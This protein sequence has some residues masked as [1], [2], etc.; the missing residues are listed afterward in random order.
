MQNK[1]NLGQF[2]KQLREEK[3]VSLKE[4]ESKTGLSGSYVNRIENQSRTNPSLDSLS[5]LTKYFQIPF[6]SMGEFCD[7]GNA[8]EGEVQ[9]LDFIL[10]NE[11]YMFANLEADF[12]FKMVL[13]DLIGELENYCTKAS[14][15]RQGE[16]KIIDFVVTL[17]EK[18]LSA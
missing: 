13:R 16:A 9:N 7:C 18:L 3:G 15:S 12:E 17:R 4:I 11:R 14:V 2:I 1:L 8:V 5:R 6:S 10:L